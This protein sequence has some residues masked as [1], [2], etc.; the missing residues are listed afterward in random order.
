[1]SFVHLHNHTDFSFLDGATKA[2]DLCSTAAEMGMPA[3]AMTDHGN[4]CGAVE[5]Y[6]AAKK[7]NIKPIIGCELYLTEGSRKERGK[8]IYGHNK[9]RYHL[10]LLAKNR[11]GYHNLMKLSS[12]GYLEGFYH[13]PRVDYE[14]LEQLHEGL[15][16]L[17]GCIQSLL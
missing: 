3:V 15:I 14:I 11:T 16:C 5:F 9:P 17:S 10:L 7:A 6:T 13:R 4:L 12:S 8:D 2:A 1:M